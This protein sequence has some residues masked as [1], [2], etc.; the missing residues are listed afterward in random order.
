MTKP[1]SHCSPDCVYCGE[2]LGNEAPVFVGGEPMHRCCKNK[3]RQDWD[4]ADARQAQLEAEGEVWAA[5]YDDDPSPYD[6]NYSE[7]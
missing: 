4:Q 3:Y 7:M 2:S 6:G 5:Q 1:E